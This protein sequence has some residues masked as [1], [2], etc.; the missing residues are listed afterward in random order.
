MHSYMHV[1]THNRLKQEELSFFFH[2]IKIS[3]NQNQ[4]CVPNWE[5]SSEHDR[6]YNLAASHPIR[7]I[8]LTLLLLYV[9]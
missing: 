6:A 3:F 1:E 9:L 5:Y 4:L 2:S 7:S 8:F